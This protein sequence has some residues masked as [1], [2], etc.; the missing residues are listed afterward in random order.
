MAALKIF[1]KKPVEKKEKPKAGIAKATA[2][3][4]KAAA[5]MSRHIMSPHITEKA[6]DLSAKDQ[7]VF[8]VAQKAN[9][10]DIAQSVGKMYGVNVQHVRIV[11]VHSKRMRLGRIEG[12]KKGYKKA[13]V[14]LK[15]GQ[16]IDILPT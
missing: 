9:K 16:K 5:R 14:K 3:P 15:A 1:G 6:T 11:N 8:V 10:R 4:P 7:Y 12:T 13:F 2:Q